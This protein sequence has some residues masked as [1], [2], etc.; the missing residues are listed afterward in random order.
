MY[1]RP[2]GVGGFGVGAGGLAS[3]GFAFGLW[4]A[5]GVGLVVAGLLLLRLAVFRRD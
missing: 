1:G 2:G 3:T 5:V 4:A